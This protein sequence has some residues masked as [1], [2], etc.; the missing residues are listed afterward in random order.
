M[1]LLLLKR[2]QMR[3]SSRSL[4]YFSQKSVDCKSSFGDL[5]YMYITAALTIADDLH[6]TSFGLKS[7]CLDY[8]LTAVS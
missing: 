4:F 2:S 3:R 8:V 5:A 7:G 6:H 1:F